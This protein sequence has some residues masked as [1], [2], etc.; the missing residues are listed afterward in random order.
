MT[1]LTLRVGVRTTVEGDVAMG[2]VDATSG[3]QVGY[4]TGPSFTIASE[5]VDAVVE[6]VNVGA[7]LLEL[8]ESSDEPVDYR[9][10]DARRIVEWIRDALAEEREARMEARA[11]GER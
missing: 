3:H 10:G 1:P 8:A 6:A 4:I 9:Q 2:L 5:R 7:K 11:R